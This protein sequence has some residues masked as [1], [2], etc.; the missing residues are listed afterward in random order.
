MSWKNVHLHSKVYGTRNFNTFLPP[1][2]WPIGKP[3]YIIKDEGEFTSMNRYHPPKP[4]VDRGLLHSL[5]AQFHPNIFL[6]TRF[7]PKGTIG[8]VRARN[9]HIID[10]VFRYV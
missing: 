3:F 1:S 2:G 10:V 4:S 8:I 9:S 6:I 7:G 5:L